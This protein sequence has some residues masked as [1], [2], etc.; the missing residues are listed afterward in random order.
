M[1][2]CCTNFSTKI[3]AEIFMN[4]FQKGTL[5]KDYERLVKKMELQAHPSGFFP[6]NDHTEKE[7]F[8]QNHENIRKIVEIHNEGIK[9]VPALSCLTSTTCV[10]VTKSRALIL[11][12]S[13]ALSPPF[14][15]TLKSTI[16]STHCRTKTMSLKL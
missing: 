5:S 6:P 10:G 3:K 4:I 12:N 11:Y 8:I 2:K 15:F 14:L 16:C 7:N 1:Q 9:G 13:S